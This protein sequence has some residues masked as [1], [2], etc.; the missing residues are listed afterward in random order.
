MTGLLADGARAAKQIYS[1]EREAG[2]SKRTI[3]RAQKALGV[4]AIKEGLTSGW[5]WK[6]PPKVA[7]VAEDGH[8]ICMDAFDTVGHLRAE[9][10]VPGE[11]DYEG[12]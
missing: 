4:E 5:V 3:R 9:S 2:Y 7:I 1:E 8:T 10:A 6:L 12:F 11:P